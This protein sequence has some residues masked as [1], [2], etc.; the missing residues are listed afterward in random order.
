AELGGDA[1]DRF[2]PGNLAPRIGDLV[3]DHR[4]RDAIL[5]CGIAVGEA[6]LDAG[7]AAVSLAIL[8][9]HHA[10]DFLAAHLG[11]ERASDAA[12]S[13]G[14]D[15]RVLGLTDLDHAL[16]GQRRRRAGLYTGAARDAF[17]FQEVLVHPG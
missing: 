7:M 10:H 2:I 5:M 11:L 6:A 17:R 4:L 15:R 16:L 12:I 9:R 1:I 13:A 8:P 14:G 3:A